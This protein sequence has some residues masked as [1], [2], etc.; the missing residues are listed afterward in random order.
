MTVSTSKDQA[1]LAAV[2]FKIAFKT[3]EI[4]CQANL[5]AFQIRLLVLQCLPIDFIVLHLKLR[6]VLAITWLVPLSL[7]ILSAVLKLRLSQQ[8]VSFL[9]VSLMFP[10]QQV[11]LFQVDL[12][13]IR[14]E[15]SLLQQSSFKTRIFY[16]KIGQKIQMKLYRPNFLPSQCLYS[17]TPT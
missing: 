13:M 7:F 2:S 17:A 4:L 16:Q 14:R 9:V 10:I 3:F 5:F 11:I 15:V 8:Q 1:Q 6:L 12:F